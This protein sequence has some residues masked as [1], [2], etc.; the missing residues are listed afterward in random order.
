ML[1]FHILVQEVLSFLLCLFN[2]VAILFYFRVCLPSLLIFRLSVF[3]A[4]KFMGIPNHILVN[5]YLFECSYFE[6][7][8]VFSPL[9]TRLLM[10]NLYFHW[11][12]LG[13]RD[14]IT[15]VVKTSIQFFSNVFID[16]SPVK[17]AAVLMGLLL[18]SIFVPARRGLGVGLEVFRI[19]PLI[20]RIFILLSRR[21]RNFIQ[22]DKLISL[23]DE[24][25]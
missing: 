5:Q 24:A 15:L 9:G 17:V 7:H 11:L 4:K 16:V 23:Q 20:F 19:F 21:L 12:G 10:F 25:G 2:F 14:I 8:W 1:I 3:L 22:K 6:F 18:G 13:D